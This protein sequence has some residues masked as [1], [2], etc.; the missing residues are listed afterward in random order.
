MLSIVRARRVLALTL[1]LALFAGCAPMR[2]DVTP[3]AAATPAPALTPSPSIAPVP[4]PSPAPQPEYRLIETESVPEPEQEPRDI[5]GEWAGYISQAGSE[6]PY[7]EVPTYAAKLNIDDQGA[8]LSLDLLQESLMDKP[9]GG[10]LPLSYARAGE[11]ALAFSAGGYAYRQGDMPLKEGD[12]FTLTYHPFY[13]EEE[14]ESSPV[15]GS[16]PAFY[17]ATGDTHDMLCGTWEGWTLSFTRLESE[18]ATNELQ[19]RRIWPRWDLSFSNL[20]N[21]VRGVYS[22]G[23]TGAD[24]SNT[25]NIFVFTD[26]AGY[27][28]IRYNYNELFVPQGLRGAGVFMEMEPVWSLGLGMSQTPVW[29]TLYTLNTGTGA[30]ED[31]SERYR[32][33]YR[34]E[35]LPEAERTLLY[36]RCEALSEPDYNAAEE[37]ER[38]YSMAYSAAFG[39]APSELPQL[40]E[41]EA[42]SETVSADMDG[43]GEDE[44]IQVMFFDFSADQDGG[45]GVWFNV[46]GE[47]DIAYI[48]SGDTVEREISV[49]DWDA[50]KP[51]V[52]LAFESLV[53]DDRRVELFTL[54]DGKVKRLTN[55]PIAG[56]VLHP[57]AEDA[58]AFNGDGTA[59]GY[60]RPWFA[61]RLLME[62]RY[63]AMTDE[64]Y[65]GLIDSVPPEDGLYR[66]LPGEP[67]VLKEPFEAYLQG[68][69]AQRIEI[70]AGQ[71]ITP[72]FSD[73][74][75]FWGETASGQAFYADCDTPERYPVFE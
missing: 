31:V 38:Y 48:L 15:A 23:E 54:S 62:M 50:E 70:F 65:A 22:F 55:G 2:T 40:P 39:Q 12:G 18:A 19:E 8:W 17:S 4:T 14:R 26:Q 1:L 47:W 64:H 60:A 68:T 3:G 57:G 20:D 35:I 41:P 33:Y 34:D 6:F 72:A 59:T 42:N 25:T 27:E 10:G 52:E 37:Y 74:W 73:G 58:I 61:P 66:L 63:A 21:N 51:G 67:L 44:T 36:E 16:S 9:V 53:L 24:N 56:S 30:F 75:L 43:D 29:E 45:V 5:F 32:G 69:D 46:D 71:R 13:T 7:A 11:A 49:V 28:R